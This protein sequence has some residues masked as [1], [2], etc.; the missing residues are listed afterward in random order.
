ML[1]EVT[2]S[3]WIL[4]KPIFQFIPS[5]HESQL[6]R[7]SSQHCWRYGLKYMQLELFGG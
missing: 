1:D 3:Q 2:F 5:I 4:L 7:L 6:I